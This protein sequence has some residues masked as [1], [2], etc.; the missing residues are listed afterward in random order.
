MGEVSNR[1]AGKT[2]NAKGTKG[3]TSCCHRFSL[4]SLSTFF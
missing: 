4:Y 1:A 2:T 3:E